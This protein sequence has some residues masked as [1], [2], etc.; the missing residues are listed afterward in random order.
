M[1]NRGSY[2]NSVGISSTAAPC[3]RHRKCL[4]WHHEDDEPE[5]QNARLFESHDTSLVQTRAQWF[6]SLGLSHPDG[7]VLHQQGWSAY[8]PRRAHGRS[9]RQW[10][11][12][13]G[14]VQHRARAARHAPPM[15]DVTPLDIV[16]L[17]L[18]LLAAILFLALFT[19]RPF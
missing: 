17:G 1:S 14:G 2:Q 6:R 16:R 11:R 5:Q 9:P 7:T 4:H 12:D 15:D 3:R 10:P 19:S 13:G 8:A 18:F